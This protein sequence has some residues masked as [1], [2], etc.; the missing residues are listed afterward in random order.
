MRLLSLAS[1]SFLPPLVLSDSK[2]P[3]GAF[4]KTES[5][6]GVCG[7]GRGW[8]S[9]KRGSLKITLK[10]EPLLPNARVGCCLNKI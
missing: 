1:D 8:Q 3:I 5:C 7:V 6:R 10:L 4:D 2:F 9:K